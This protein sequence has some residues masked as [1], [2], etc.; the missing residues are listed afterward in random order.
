MMIVQFLKQSP[1]AKVSQKEFVQF[2]RWEYEAHLKNVCNLLTDN[3]KPNMR[4]LQVPFCVNLW[5][6]TPPL[7]LHSYSLSQANRGVAI[8][9]Y[10]EHNDAFD[11]ISAKKC[12]HQH[13]YYEFIY[14]YQGSYAHTMNGHTYHYH[15]NQCLMLEPGIYHEDTASLRPGCTIIFFCVSRTFFE[16]LHIRYMAA[17]PARNASKRQATGMTSP[18]KSEAHLL[19][20][21]P[22][23]PR[24]TELTRVL[25]EQLI[26][27]IV[28]NQIGCELVSEGLFYRLIGFL[29][30]ESL[31][32]CEQ[33]AISFYE[34]ER[35]NTS[36]E[37]QAYL[38]SRN[39]QATRKEITEQFNY[40]ADYLNRLL[41]RQT[42]WTISKY[43]QHIALKRAEQMLCETDMSVAEII[44]ELG[45]ENKSFFYRLFERNSGMTP[46]EYRFLH[47]KGETA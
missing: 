24:S 21:E 41:K 12:A 26:S 3:K 37:L 29:Y 8:F 30:D 23:S 16:T 4:M 31:Y 11:D 27:E 39:G 33:K 40:C 17:S 9:N 47:V 13:N 6:V 7:T 45:F 34:Q 5:N 42:G 44:A 19:V 28:Q 2:S 32:S 10:A 20:Y 36:E 43:N 14:V 22:L 38:W 18:D 1:K 15:E 46:S 35:L 25:A